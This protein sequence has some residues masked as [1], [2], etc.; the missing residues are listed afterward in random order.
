[1]D[2]GT[3]VVVERVYVFQMGSS[4][5]LRPLSPIEA[6]AW[7]GMPLPIIAADIGMPAVANNFT[8]E[9]LLKLCGRA[10]HA[11]C[12]AVAVFAAI[13]VHFSEVTWGKCWDC[14]A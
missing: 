3:K 13:L 7:Q 14:Q 6:F 10:F 12:A 4:P 1:M 2:H 8:Y 5:Q 11:P 9:D